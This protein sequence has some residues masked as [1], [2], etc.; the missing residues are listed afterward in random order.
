MHNLVLCYALISNN[1]ADAALVRCTIYTQSEYYTSP[2]VT[3][4]LLYRLSVGTRFQELM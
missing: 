2:K 1:A 4:L 3:I